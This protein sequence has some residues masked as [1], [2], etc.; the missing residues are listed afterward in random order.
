MRNRNRALAIM[1]PMG[2][3]SWPS[4][5]YQ[6]RRPAGAFNASSEGRPS[7]EPPSARPCRQRNRLSS[8]IAYMP[9]AS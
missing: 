7:H 5:A 3:P 4:M 6:P 8:R 9:M 2:A 1:K